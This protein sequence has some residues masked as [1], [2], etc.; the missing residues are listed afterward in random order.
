[1]S[2]VLARLRLRPVCARYGARGSPC[3]LPRAPDGDTDWKHIEEN[4]HAAYLVKRPAYA[5]TL[6]RTGIRF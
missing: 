2:M 6:A 3:P 1:M 4:H 5:F